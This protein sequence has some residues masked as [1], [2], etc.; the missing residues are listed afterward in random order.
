MDKDVLDHQ[1]SPAEYERIRQMRA[2]LE[3][4]PLQKRIQRIMDCFAELPASEQ[5]RLAQ[6][7]DDLEGRDYSGGRQ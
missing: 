6:F 1:L 3:S 7:R 2:E 5:D 4:L